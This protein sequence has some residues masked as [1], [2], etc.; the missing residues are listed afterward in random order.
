MFKYFTMNIKLLGLFCFLCLVYFIGFGI[1]TMDVDAAQY[2]SISREMLASGSYLQVFDHGKDYLDKPPF[3]FWISALSMKIFGINNF[4]Y[5]FP[6]FLFSLLAVYATYKFSLL[7]YSKKIALL[8]AVLL[9]CCQ[10]F[11]LMNHDVRTD[12]I[13]M[14]W[15]MFSIW[16]LAAWYKN[17]KL[18]H[19]IV[20]CLAIAGG[21]MTKGPIALLV[22][23]FCFGS[24]FILERRLFK[25][26]FRWQYILGILIIALLLLPMCIGLYSQFDLHPEKIV[27]DATGVSGLRFF[28]WTQ[29]FGRITGESTWNNNHNIFFLFQNLLWAFLPWILFFIIAFYFEIKKIIQQKFKLSP[30]QEWIT[31]GGFI[32]TYLA[33]GSSKYQLPHYLFVALPLAAIITAR[34][35][36]KLIYQ[37]KYPALHKHLKWIHFILFILLWLILLIMLYC[38]N[39]PFWIEITAALFAAGYFALHFYYYH[40]PKYLLVICIFTIS[41][42]NLFLN[43]FLYPALL[44]YQ[45]G[46][47]VG[48][49]IY[50]NKLPVKKFFVYQYENPWSLGFYS[51]GNIQKQDSITNISAGDYII[52]DEK[53]LHDFDSIGKK[54][55]ILYTGED[56]HISGLKLKFINPSFRKTQ[57]INYAVIKVR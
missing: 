10:A 4:A 52:T 36:Y 32:L 49:W 7:Y 55:T 48:K 18:Y 23:A 28:F 44:K 17:N 46:S 20:A 54:Y 26:L 35:L 51:Q 41:G 50:T 16:Q 11:F 21:M 2:A 14:G 53:K 12:T 39:A 22:P 19:F 29:S 56:F 37:Q 1:D 27:N 45:M 43:G 33:L 47:S 3:L 24:H 5:R 40:S 38:F 25:M 57:V 31:T 30:G 8:S 6:S 34:F 9:A 13:L 15:V 42:I